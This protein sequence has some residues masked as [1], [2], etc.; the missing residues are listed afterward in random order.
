MLKCLQALWK[1]DRAAVINSM[2]CCYLL[3]FIM[4][5]QSISVLLL[6]CLCLPSWVTHIAM[7]AFS[8]WGPPVMIAL[9]TTAWQPDRNRV[10]DCDMSGCIGHCLQPDR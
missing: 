1:G 5:L 10:S 7:V 2:V 8:L 3:P 4:T 6:F 9:M